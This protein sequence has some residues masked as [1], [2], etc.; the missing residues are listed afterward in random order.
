MTLLLIDYHRAPH[1]LDVELQHALRRLVL[2]GAIGED[3]ATAARAD[4]AD[5]TIV[6]YPHVVVADRMWELRHNVTAYDAAFLSLAETLGV[7]LVTCDARLSRVLGHTASVEVFRGMQALSGRS[8]LDAGGLGVVQA[9]EVHDL[10]QPPPGAGRKSEGGS[11]A[12][13]SVVSSPG[14]T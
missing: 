12:K 8:N 10:D 1:L 13:D 9:A 11:T 3:R 2:S 4:F 14:P 5:L 7:P 6:R